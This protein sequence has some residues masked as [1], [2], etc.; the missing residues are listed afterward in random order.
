MPPP[1]PSFASHPAASIGVAPGDANRGGGLGFASEAPA[2]AEQSLPR[3]AESLALRG[4]GGSLG[5]KSSAIP[6]RSPALPA[7]G[8]SATFSETFMIFPPCRNP[9]GSKAE[10]EMTRFNPKK[11]RRKMAVCDRP[12][13][14][15]IAVA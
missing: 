15:G 4:G 6:R 2:P 10:T 8:L 5:S 11:G 12:L 1:R 9:S 14:G 7:A 13:S 3:R